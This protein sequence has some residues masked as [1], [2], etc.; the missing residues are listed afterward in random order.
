MAN[1]PVE[2]Q[3]ED[4]HELIVCV[5]CVT[6]M[7]VS[8]ELL[9]QDFRRLQLHAQEEERKKATLRAVSNYN[10]ALVR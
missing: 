10:E 1:A 7:L 5:I 6:D 4:V 8:K 3:G 9:Q 2:K